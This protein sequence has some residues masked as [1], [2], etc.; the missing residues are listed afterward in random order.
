MN[1]NKSMQKVSSRMIDNETYM[2]HEVGATISFDVDYREMII[3]RKKVQIYYVNGLVDDLIVTE[4]LEKL[5]SINDEEVEAYEMYDIIKNRLINLQVT[6]ERDLAKLTDEMLSGLIVVFIEGEK[7]GFIVDVR[8]YPGRDPEEPDT[9]RVIRGARDGFTENIVQNCALMR[10]RIKDKH[11][12]NEILTVGTRSK[13]D[14][15]ISYINDVA[16]DDLIKTLKERLEK[17]DIDGLVMADKALEE[18]IFEH[19]WNPY[20]AVRYTER[21]DV[22]AHHVMSGYVVLVVDTSPTVMIVPTT[23][24]DHLEHAEEYRQTPAVG[25][26]TRL[27]R[28]LAI[29]SSLYLLPVWLLFVLEPSLLPK[30]LSFIGPEKTGSIPIAIQILIGIIGVEFLR[31]AAV[32]TPTP[33]A[34]ALGLI[35]AVL[36]GDIAIDVGMFSPEV[37]LYVA[38]STIGSYVTPSYELSVANKIIH[39]LVLILTICFGVSG[40]V[41]GCTLSILFLVNIQY[42]NTPYFWPLIPF[43]FTAFM[44]FLLR[45]PVPY[46]R[47]RPSIVHP[48]N[49]IRLRYEKE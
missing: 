24:F 20:P 34:T 28:I 23:F 1:N 41:I 7:Q 5:V 18:F 35:A 49:K 46:L 10:R 29:L 40:F 42:L 22:A 11:L 9:E 3:L 14:V 25:T 6:P 39:L 48:K 43:N 8:F 21:P 47:K 45:I 27:I 38:L 15:C 4:I 36:I 32:H 17:V 16:N 19:K 44:R 26:F 31:M 37:I 2:K 30:S 12:R 33:L 13:T